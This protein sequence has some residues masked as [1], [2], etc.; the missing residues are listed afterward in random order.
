MSSTKDAALRYLEAGLSVIPVRPDKKPH[1][2][3]EKYQRQQPSEEEIERWYAQLPNAGVAVVC[4]AVSGEIAVLD[5]DDAD[6]SAWL[7]NSCHGVLSKSWTVRTGSGK[8]HYYLRSRRPVLT[9][10]LKTEEGITLADIR[11]NGREPKGPSY[12]LAPPSAY[13]TKGIKSKYTTIFGGPEAIATVADAKAFFLKLASRFENGVPSRE[14]REK[15]EAEE[16][17]PVGT[18][19]ADSEILPPADEVEE[20]RLLD[21]LE[22]SCLNGVKRRALLEDPNP[23]GY[24]RT[25]MKADK[26]GLDYSA[27]DYESMNW[28]LEAGFGMDDCRRFFATFPLGAYRYRNNTNGKTY[29]ERYFK[30]TYANAAENQARKAEAAK[31]AA[32]DNFTVV[33]VK[34]LPYDSPTYEVVINPKDGIVPN[35]KSSGYP[36]TV[37]L[38]LDT[39]HREGLFRKTVSGVVDFEPQFSA[40]QIKDFSKFTGALLGMMTRD[41]V[42]E[43]A[44]RRG[45]LKKMLQQLL[46]DNLD[47][48][49]P[50][51][52][53]DARIGWIIDGKIY[54]Q[55]SKLI[56]KLQITLGKAAPTG[57]DVWELLRGAGATTMETTDGELWQ[58]SEGFLKE[59]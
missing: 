47:R 48:V 14:V 51:N 9:T 19:L 57:E 38:D 1:I 20:A 32:G 26:S 30:V 28:L 52:T 53:A 36:R 45:L 22:H 33:S 6:F 13:D 25:K 40:N 42:P 4:G 3:W 44:T 35:P 18:R 7:E 8:L 16:F 29:G 39:I 37:V 49:K 34:K 27:I 2:K 10:K 17:E 11:G 59:K 43:E 12:V 50:E 56:V 41:P 23:R 21:R 5:V 55:G 58:L 54:L 15:K 31:E 24:W 46:D